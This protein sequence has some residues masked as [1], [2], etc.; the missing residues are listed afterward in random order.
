MLAAN[1]RRLLISAIAAKSGSRSW[2]SWR[3]SSA[4]T[5]AARRDERVEKRK[6]Q[7]RPGIEAPST[8]LPA[9]HGKSHRARQ[10]GARL[11][12]TMVE[13][14]LLDASLSRPQPRHPRILRIRARICSHDR[15]RRTP[16]SKSFMQNCLNSSRL[17]SRKRASRASHPL[18][19]H[20]RSIVAHP[21]FGCTKLFSLAHHDA[22]RLLLRIEYD[23][24]TELSSDGGLWRGI[25]VIGAASP[26]RREAVLG[27]LLDH[28]RSVLA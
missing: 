3:S 27:A 21:L 12:K 11:L 25:P 6:G 20:R 16:S 14:A 18:I 2:K 23:G 5:P 15:S 22:T 9:L 1:R 28:L 8:R 17:V 24:L 13:I 7:R 26:A 4:K 19:F 10:I